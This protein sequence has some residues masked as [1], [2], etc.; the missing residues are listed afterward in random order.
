MNTEIHTNTSYQ[1]EHLTF[2][3]YVLRTPNKTISLS[4]P[5]MLEL[6]RKINELTS[7]SSLNRI[8]DNENFVLLFV[9]DKQHLI[10]LEIPQLLQLKEEIALV[11]HT[12]ASVLV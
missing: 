11:F 7:Y 2:C 8:I 5:Q 9:A 1:I 10:F 12:P 3:K 6:R 4:F